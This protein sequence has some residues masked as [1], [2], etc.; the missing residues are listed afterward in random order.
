VKQHYKGLSFVELPVDDFAQA[1]RFYEHT[2]EL[3]L[4]HLDEPNLWCLYTVPGSSTGVALYGLP[5]SNGIRQQR[6]AARLVLRVDNLDDV[7][8][9]LMKRGV[10]VEP[11]RIHTEEAF[12]I[13]GFTDMDGN[14]WRIWSPLTPQTA[15]E[16]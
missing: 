6:S 13:S 8:D 1:R 2:L 11:V 12:R 9:K 15:T 4:T 7:L 10:S 14:I 3:A 16:I 5:A